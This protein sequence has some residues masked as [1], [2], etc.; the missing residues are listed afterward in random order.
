MLVLSI[1]HYKYSTAVVATKSNKKSKKRIE[2]QTSTAIA[3]T[4]ANNLNALSD[5]DRLQIYAKLAA[6]LKLELQNCDNA[7]GIIFLIVYYRSF[8][9]IY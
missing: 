9:V 5:K 6:K 7:L 2:L 3:A 4:D 8:F 1:C